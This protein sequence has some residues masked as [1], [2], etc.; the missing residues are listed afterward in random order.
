[1]QL[2]EF[3]RKRGLGR[4]FACQLTLSVSFQFSRSRS[5]A[6][7]HPPHCQSGPCKEWS[8][9]RSLTQTDEQ[10]TQTMF[11]ALQETLI[12]AHH[13][14]CAPLGSFYPPGATCGVCFE[15]RTGRREAATHCNLCAASYRPIP[16]VEVLSMARIASPGCTPAW[17]AGPPVTGVTTTSIGGVPLSK[18]TSSPTPVTAP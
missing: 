2:E 17:S 7:G 5:G 10:L 6:L 1:M 16:S 12:I 4:I 3:E 11:A 13:C 15:C 8:L 18:P 9:L 14:H